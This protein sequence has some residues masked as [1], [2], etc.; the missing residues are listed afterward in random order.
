[1]AFFLPGHITDAVFWVFVHINV[2][3][4]KNSTTKIIIIIKILF[5]F[6]DSILDLII[7]QLCLLTRGHELIFST[8]I[9]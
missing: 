6:P 8:M 4:S 2:G 5:L 9:K 1:M 3:R 7:F